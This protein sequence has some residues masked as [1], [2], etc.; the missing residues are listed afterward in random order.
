MFRAVRVLMCV[1]EKRTDAQMCC[2]V[3]MRTHTETNVDAWD[4]KP[5]A[6]LHGVAQDNIKRYDSN[7]LDSRSC[8]CTL[9][10]AHKERNRRGM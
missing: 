1:M 6:P 2:V 5:N 8:T 9:Y 10:F 7:L 4:A 3:A